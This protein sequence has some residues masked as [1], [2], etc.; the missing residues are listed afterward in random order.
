MKR[1][2]VLYAEKN[3]W[4]GNRNIAQKNVWGWGNKATK[5][6][7]FVARILKIPKVIKFVVAHE[8]VQKF[9]VKIFISLVYMIKR[10]ILCMKIYQKKY[11]K[12]EKKIIG[13][14]SIGLFLRQMEK[15]LNVITY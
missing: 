6:V 4:V 3:W 13:F 7:L 15:Y 11:K 8:S 1:N 14:Q 12:L 10:S 2:I 9:I 5:F